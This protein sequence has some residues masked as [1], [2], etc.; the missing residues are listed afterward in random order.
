MKY[1]SGNKLLTTMELSTTVRFCDYEQCEKGLIKGIIESLILWI[2][3]S[4]YNAKNLKHSKLIAL[5]FQ[6]SCTDL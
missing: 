4:Y 5:L 2:H 6:L 1:H 3:A